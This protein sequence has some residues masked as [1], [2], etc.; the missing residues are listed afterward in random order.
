MENRHFF[1]AII[2]ISIV[3]LLFSA[4]FLTNDTKRND[5]DFQAHRGGK[6]LMPE[7]TIPAMLDAINRNVTTLEM[8][9][10]VSK[11]KQVIVAHDAYFNPKFATTPEGD[12]LSSRNR[13]FYSMNYDSI[14]RYDV[15]MR[16]IPEFPRQKKMPVSVPLLSDLIDQTEAFSVSK[17]RNIRYNIEIKSNSKKDGVE[18]PVPDEYVDLVINLLKNKDIM[19]RVTIQSFDMRPLRVINRRYPDVQ[20]SLLVH[21]DADKVEENLT[22]LGFIPYSYNP[23]Y[24]YVTEDL[25]KLCHAK[26]M[27]VIPWTVNTEE[28]IKAIMKLGVDGIISD[29]PDLFKLEK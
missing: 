2:T 6:G 16:F 10:Y 22:Q 21:K 28:E 17:K 11:D 5:F 8:D 9:L 13:L 23:Q 1:T 3:S 4:C 24:K 12:S 7:N 19:E 15:G 27:K 25:V 20:L 14:K 26:K 29:Y 18:H